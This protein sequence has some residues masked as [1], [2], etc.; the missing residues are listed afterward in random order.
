MQGHREGDLYRLR[1]HDMIER[2]DNDSVKNPDT[3]VVAPR[4]RRR[5]DGAG[6]CAS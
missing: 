2:G 5:E 4:V 6:S 3:G 1:L